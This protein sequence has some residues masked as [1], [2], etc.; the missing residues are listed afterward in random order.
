M[1]QTEALFRVKG[2]FIGIYVRTEGDYRAIA[3]QPVATLGI[4]FW[5]IKEQGVLDFMGSGSRGIVKKDRHSPTRSLHFHRLDLWRGSSSPVMDF[6]NRCWHWMGRDNEWLM[7]TCTWHR[8]LFP[9]SPLA[10]LLFKS[11]WAWIM[12]CSLLSHE[13]GPF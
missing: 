4:G 6:G 11:H 1:V 12:L 7:K 5:W 13:P 8:P 10:W 2:V 3:E 9:E